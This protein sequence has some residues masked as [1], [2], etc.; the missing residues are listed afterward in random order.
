[1]TS[2]VGPTAAHAAAYRAE[3]RIFALAL[4]LS[5]AVHWAAFAAAP[6]FRITDVRMIGESV[7]TVDLA[8]PEVEIPP[9]PEAIARPATPVASVTEIDQTLTIAPTTFESNPVDL[10]PPPPAEANADVAAAPTFTPFTVKPTLRN[11]QEI[12]RLLHKA[13]PPVL[14]D[15]GIGGTVLVWIFLDRNGVVQKAQV[16]TSSGYD[17]FDEAALR[18]APQMEFTPA[19]NRDQRVDVWIAI[20]LVFESI[21]GLAERPGTM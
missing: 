9:L 2:I 16:K 14:R 12:A 7:E 4:T 11:G 13:Y 17:A 10:L 3:T 6:T 19:L 21:V 15:A 20:D 18:V 5:V 1:M 8:P